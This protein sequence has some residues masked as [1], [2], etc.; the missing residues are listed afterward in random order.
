MSFGE[1]EQMDRSPFRYVLKIEQATVTTG[2][3][4]SEAR[5]SVSGLT[6]RASGRDASPELR[7]R[8]FLNQSPRSPRRYPIR[9]LVLLSS[10][11]VDLVGRLSILGMTK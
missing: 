9:T 6:S 11:R 5:R 10:G 2:L 3:S 8:R 7:K 1:M 4:I